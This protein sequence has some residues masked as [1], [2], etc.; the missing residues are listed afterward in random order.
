VTAAAAVPDR[1]WTVR[2]VAAYLGK[3]TSWVS[4]NRH[5]LPAPL[6]IGGELRWKRED[7][8]AWTEAQR[9]A[10]VLPFR[11]PRTE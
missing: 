5:Q 1:L 7:L 11:P 2:D 3:S 10:R 9:E 6:R 4:H 8:E